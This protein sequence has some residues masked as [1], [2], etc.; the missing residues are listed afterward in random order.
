MKLYTVHARAPRPASVPSTHAVPAG[1]PV[2]L[3]E[4]FSWFA[5]LFGVFWFL[6]NRLWWEA[7]LM[8]ALS[9]A[10]A[11]LLPEAVDGLALLALHA[12]AGFEA[13]DRLRA[14]LVRRGLDFQGVVVA[15]NLDF[16]W[17]RLVETRPDLVATI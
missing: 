9:V 3:A 11:L 17:F 8:L 14:R 6:G 2:L 5:A 12:L 4:G 16:A 15:P 10:A 1:L 7:A 13:R